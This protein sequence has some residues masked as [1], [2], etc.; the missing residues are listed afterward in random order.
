[1]LDSC[2]L[3]YRQGILLDNYLSSTE[4]KCCRSCQ[5]FDWDSEMTSP[6]DAKTPNDSKL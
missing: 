6:P 1:M 5:L 3:E 2:V 4:Q